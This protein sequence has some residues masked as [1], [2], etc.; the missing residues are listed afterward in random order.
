MPAVNATVLVQVVAKT[1]DRDRDD[2]IRRLSGPG[3]ASFSIPKKK[4]VHSA[5]A[6]RTDSADEATANDV[7]SGFARHLEVV[8]VVVVEVVVGS[9]G[10]F[11][12][13]NST[14]M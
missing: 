6:Q 11:Q 10:M 9:N 14:S 13:G 7:H 3:H 5:A 2:K 8:D 12:I 1:S 4:R